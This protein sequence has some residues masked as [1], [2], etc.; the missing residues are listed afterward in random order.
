[1]VGNLAVLAGWAG[2]HKRRHEDL[3]TTCLNLDKRLTDLWEVHDEQ[4]KICPVTILQDRQEHVIKNQDAMQDKLDHLIERTNRV[5][6]LEAKMDASEKDRS[7]MNTKLDRLIDT[8]G[9]LRGEVS[10]I[11]Q[12]G[13]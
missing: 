12:G 7:S 5:E 8:V 9:Q 4:M 3:D 6:R 11:R 10:S 13:R 2:Y 1:M